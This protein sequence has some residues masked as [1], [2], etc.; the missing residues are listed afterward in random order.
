MWP[1]LT[2][3]HEA[4]AWG[5]PFL[6]FDI[7]R[8]G[9]HYRCELVS[10]NAASQASRLARSS[11]SP[12]EHHPPSPTH[13]VKAI[14]PPLSE[15]KGISQAT[16]SDILAERLRRGPFRDVDDLYQRLPLARETLEQLV[17][18]GVFDALQQRRV[19]L[20]RVGALSTAH[21]PGTRMLLSG[22]PP[23]PRLPALP[24]E[25][26]FV[27]DFQTTRLSTLEVHPADLV[28]DQLRE[29]GCTPLWRARRSTRHTVLRTA[30]MVVA[31][32]K[33]P[34]AKGFAF[35]VIEDGPHRAQLIISPDLWA[36]HRVLLRDSAFLVV[37]VSVADT[38]HQPALKA[39]TL[40]SLPLPISVRGY[41]YGG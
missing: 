12:R 16:A 17:R 3:R 25:Q 37:D 36:S 19:A 32:Q 28:R 7:N 1:Q 27:W 24:D 30:G 38:G 20:Y 18:A 29:L 8:S 10:P 33:P 39:L 6:P 31:R 23:T 11:E 5:V 4:R 2:K 14:R 41:H 26:R 21:E 40:A 34:T 13:R 22:T 35:F 9:A 15:I